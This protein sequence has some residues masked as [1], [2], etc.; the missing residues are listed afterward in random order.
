MKNQARRNTMGIIHISRVQGRTIRSN[1][2]HNFGNNEPAHKIDFVKGNFEMLRIVTDICQKRKE[3]CHSET[4]KNWKIRNT[5]WNKLDIKYGKT[6]RNPNNYGMDKTL[7]IAFRNFERNLS[8]VFQSDEKDQSP[9]FNI[10][11]I[12]E[13]TIDSE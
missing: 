6:D 10:K 5:D 3:S 4:N 13:K 11:Q 9:R 8:K 1:K 7:S 2:I 12:N